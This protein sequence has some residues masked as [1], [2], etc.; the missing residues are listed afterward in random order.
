MTADSDW[1]ILR[2]MKTLTIEVPDAVV[3]WLDAVARQRQQTL[4]QAASAA[5]A[6]AAGRQAPT[7]GDLVADLAGIGQGK[8]SDLSTNKEHLNDFGR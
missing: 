1:P 7:F 8:H 4:E 5:L 3:Q 2:C 6:S